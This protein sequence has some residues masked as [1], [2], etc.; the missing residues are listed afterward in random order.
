LEFEIYKNPS[1]TGFLI[2]IE[3]CLS[4]KDAISHI[5]YLVNR[6]NTYPLSKEAKD[7]EINIIKTHY[8]TVIII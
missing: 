6:L 5:H 1:E 2:F 4:Y 8:I 7:T 3:S